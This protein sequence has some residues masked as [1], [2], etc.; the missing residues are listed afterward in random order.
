MLDQAFDALKSYDWG[1]DRSALNPIDEAVVAAHTDPPAGAKL[2]ARL[3]AVLGMDVNRA[4]IDY[5]CRKLM[6]FGTAASVP[7]LARL[8]PEQEHSHMAR[9]ALERIPAAEAA[10]VL[11]D[12]LS[13]LE[14]ELKVGVIGSLGVRQDEASVGPLAA[15]LGDGDPQV[16][17]AAA[18]ALGAICTADAGKALLKA[19]AAPGAIGEDTKLAT[20]DAALACAEGLLAD[21]KNKEA[22]SL[23]QSLAGGGQPKLVRL[24]ATRGLLA[25]AGK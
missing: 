20:A 12:A 8:L 18:S 9:Y 15:M 4:A 7:A 21:G 24:A 10:Q 19:I 25:C 16:A 6:F 14:G 1:P 17:R 13:S 5:V 23:Y 3:A 11:R 2:E 22:R